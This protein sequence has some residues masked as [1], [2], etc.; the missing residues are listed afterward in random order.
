MQ[1]T[2]FF[3]R[4]KLFLRSK[5]NLY[6]L[7]FLILFPLSSYAAE[8]ESN[9]VLI[10]YYSRTGKS[11]VVC[12]VIMR[13]YCVD[14]LEIKDLKDRSGAWGFK[15]AAFD[16]MFDRYTEIEPKQADLSGY[17]LVI[18]V[19]PIWNW[20]LSVPIKTFLKDN[21]LDGKNLW[22]LPRQIWI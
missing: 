19:N 22:C 8:S 16:N 2:K 6:I 9:D 11:K 5:L 14:I 10:V 1:K 18:L 13:N 7:C 17:S 15:G 21:R 12:D 20:K 4:L 3:K